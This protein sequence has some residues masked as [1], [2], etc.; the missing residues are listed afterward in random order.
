[1]HLVAVDGAEEA[2]KDVGHARHQQPR[3]AP[4]ELPVAGVDHAHLRPPHTPVPHACCRTKRLP[5]SPPGYLSRTQ[6]LCPHESGQ[7]MQHQHAS[8][9]SSCKAATDLIVYGHLMACTAY[10]QRSRTVSLSTGTQ[11][12]APPR[13]KA[14]MRATGLPAPP[15]RRTGCTHETLDQ[16]Q[17][18]LHALRDCHYTTVRRP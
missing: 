5:P 7:N 17:T 18:R 10:W 2:I 12:A 4:A 6:R 13:D 15:S 11:A 16:S 14:V 9:R 1:M 3:V 8:E